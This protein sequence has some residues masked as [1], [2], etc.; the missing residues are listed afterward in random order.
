MFTRFDVDTTSWTRGRA[1]ETGRTLYIAV[2]V[3][4]QTVAATISSRIRATRVWILNRDS[5][6]LR[7]FNAKRI[8][9]M[10]PQ[11]LK[12]LSIRDGKTFEYLYDVYTLQ[13]GHLFSTL[14]SDYPF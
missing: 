5:R 7:R 14:H 3:E 10:K 6:R 2:V 8:E 4:G 1:E 12:E 11:I 9:G 13:E